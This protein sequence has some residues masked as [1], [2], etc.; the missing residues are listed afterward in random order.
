MLEL[1][2]FIELEEPLELELSSGVPVLPGPPK[3]G[4]I[5][6]LVAV[7][8]LLYGLSQSPVTVSPTGPWRQ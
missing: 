8:V 3:L 2:A 4:L 6:M 1:G 7:P 5:R